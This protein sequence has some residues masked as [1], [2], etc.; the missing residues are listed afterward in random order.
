MELDRTF[1]ERDSIN[2]AVV[3]ALDEAALNWGVKVLRYEIKDLT[4][5]ARSCARCR[6]RSPPSAKSAR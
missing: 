6:R 4:P 5:P 2:A 1:E 3:Q